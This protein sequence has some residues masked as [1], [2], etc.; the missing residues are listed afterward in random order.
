VSVAVLID[1]FVAASALIKLEAHE[2]KLNERKNKAVR[3][4]RERGES[5]GER[6]KE[7]ER[8]RGERDG[9]KTQTYNAIKRTCLP[10]MK[11]LEVLE[12]QCGHVLGQVVRHVLKCAPRSRPK[13]VADRLKS[14][15]QGGGSL[16]QRI[17]QSAHLFIDVNRA[18][19]DHEASQKHPDVHIVGSKSGADEEREKRERERDRDR[20]R[21]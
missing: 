7:R 8:E 9:G 16:E 6:E 15:H 17:F 5:D 2:Q 11:A 1:K 21:G 3:E 20:E 18:V 10:R 4:E 14:C 13:R 19:G 12:E